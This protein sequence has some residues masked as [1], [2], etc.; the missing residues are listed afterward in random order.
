[1]LRDLVAE[2]ADAFAA[3]F[4]ITHF[5]N[6]PRYMR[7]LE[8]TA[9]DK[10]RPEAV[11]GIRDFCHRSLGKGVVDC[12]DTPGFIANRIGIYWIQVAILE[13]MELGLTVEEADAVMGRPLGI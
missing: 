12:K 8:I 1:P 2:Q 3:D 5:F 4:M 11:D 13:A 7:L 10:T 6:P 9:G